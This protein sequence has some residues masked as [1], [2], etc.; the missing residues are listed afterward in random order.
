MELPILVET[1]PFILSHE[2][3]ENQG[4]N[5][6]IAHLFRPR[7]WAKW[8]HLPSFSPQ[9]VGE[10]CGRTLANKT[11]YVLNI[12]KLRVYYSKAASCFGHHK[13]QCTRKMADSE[14]SKFNSVK[15]TKTWIINTYTWRW[16]Q[17]KVWM[18]FR[19]LLCYDNVAR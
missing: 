5:D 9:I 16:E 18:V 14:S 17:R 12:I 8:R 3:G 7:L 11:Y 4:W 1:Q 15:L 2:M 19:K 6:V 13:P 10:N